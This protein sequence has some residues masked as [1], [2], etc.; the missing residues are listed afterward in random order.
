[1]VICGR[2]PLSYQ[3]ISGRLCFALFAAM[4]ELC[5]KEYLKSS[6][7]EYFAV[8]YFHTQP[9]GTLAGRFWA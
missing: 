7:K 6:A 4:G 8:K 2:L 1:M 9:P 5:V 3:S